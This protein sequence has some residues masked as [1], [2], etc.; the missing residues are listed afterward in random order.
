MDREGPLLEALTHRLAECPPEFLLPAGTK[1]RDA[2]FVDFIAVVA[3]HFRALDGQ[4]I[5]EL[6]PTLA[7]S[8]ETDARR[9][10]ILISVWLLH[11]EWF[12]GEPSLA[13]AMWSL[14]CDGLS[15][16]ADLVPAAEFTRDADRREELVRVCLKHLGLRPRGESV[17][18][19]M[20]RLNTLD[21]IERLRVLRDTRA[22]EAR[23]RLVRQQMARK[24]A[25]AAA[26]RYGAE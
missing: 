17:A 14:F 11:D 21:S 8:A 23:A 1:R 22:A 6:V 5:V 13:A 26:V 25:E 20:D 7:N 24:A 16:L 10:L 9:Q 4:E 2:E 3:D 18:Q 15:T 12:L 19:A